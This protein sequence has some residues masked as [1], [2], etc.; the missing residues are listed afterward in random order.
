MSK[1]SINWLLNGILPVQLVLITE[2][3]VCWRHC[4]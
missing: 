3:S 4:E 2:L 1:Y